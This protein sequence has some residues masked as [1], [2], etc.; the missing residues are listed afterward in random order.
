MGAHRGTTKEQAVHLGSQ[1]GRKGQSLLGDQCEKIQRP[2]PGKVPGYWKNLEGHSELK[3][4]PE[5]E[6]T[7]SSG[8]IHGEG[9]S[10]VRTQ[11]KGYSG[12]MNAFEDVVA[13][14]GPRF[15]TARAATS[16]KGE[17][18][19]AGKPVLGGGEYRGLAFS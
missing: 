5:H 9:T 4:A 17:F 1:L 7:A 14:N 13:L 6:A 18:I 15:R 10:S 8:H 19:R 11:L 12:G 16:K 2:F 3:G